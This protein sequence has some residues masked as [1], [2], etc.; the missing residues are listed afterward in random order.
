MLAQGVAPKEDQA[1]QNNGELTETSVAEHDFLLQ[2][3]AVPERGTS[4]QKCRIRCNPLA[5]ER[6]ATVA[7]IQH[8]LRK[9]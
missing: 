1:V 3:T 2:S 9:S 6:D 4:F 7:E 8:K 5:E